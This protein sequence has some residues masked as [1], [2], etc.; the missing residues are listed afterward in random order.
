MMYKVFISH[1]NKDAEFVQRICKILNNIYIKCYIYEFFPEY[2]EYI[3]ETIKKIIKDC[4]TVIILLTKDGVQSQWVNQEMGMA[5]AL[6]RRIIP[7]VEKNVEIKGFVELRQYIDY[8]KNNP[9][10]EEYTIYRLITR[11]RELHPTDKINLFCMN[12]NCDNHLTMFSSILPTQQEINSAIDRDHLFEY[13][14]PSC[15]FVNYIFPRTLEQDFEYP[16]V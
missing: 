11:L 6:D 2:G 5:F 14:C 10:D 12:R 3:P 16:N 9:D 15:A 13:K 7:I 8:E 1:N 4:R